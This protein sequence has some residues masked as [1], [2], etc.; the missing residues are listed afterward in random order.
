[1]TRAKDIIQANMGSPVQP[2]DTVSGERYLRLIRDFKAYEKKLR[3]T[4]VRLAAEN[5]TLHEERDRY[6]YALATISD[7]EHQQS[8]DKEVRR[9]ATLANLTLKV[10]E[11]KQRLKAANKNNP[12][13]TQNP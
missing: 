10:T 7:F 6:M 12:N 8:P 3:E 5:E 4:I 13:V 2:T 11:L 9:R 1:M